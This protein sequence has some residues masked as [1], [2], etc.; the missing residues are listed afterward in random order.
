MIELI[1]I[2]IPRTGGTSFYNIL[3]QVYGDRLSKSYNRKRY[4]HAIQ[5]GKDFSNVLDE[6]VRILEGHFNYKEVR[7]IHLNDNA[8]VLCWLRDPVERLISNHRHFTK[9]NNLPDVPSPQLHRRN[10]SLLTY[11]SREDCRNRMTKILDGI[12]LED[13]FF[14]GFLETYE[15][16]MARLADLLKW[17]TYSVPKLNAVP[18]G[19][20]KIS[21]ELRSKIK[22][23]NLDDY[24]LF[25]KAHQLVGRMT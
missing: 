20:A 8:K 2:H 18:A 21:D 1:S 10:E 17:P 7:K 6:K 24:D 5:D 23:L 19:D 15:K 9:R 14:I 12:E 13:L 11:A 25:N 22:A 16:D 4:K 3:Q